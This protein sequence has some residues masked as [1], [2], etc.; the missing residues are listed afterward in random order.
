MH[1]DLIARLRY[2]TLKDGTT[3]IYRRGSWQLLAILPP[4]YILLEPWRLIYG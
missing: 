4:G 3:K 1:T 2:V